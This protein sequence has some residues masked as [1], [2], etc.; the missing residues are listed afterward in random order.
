MNRQNLLKSFLRFLSVFIFI[1]LFVLLFFYLGNLDLVNAIGFQKDSFSSHEQATFDFK[2]I[3]SSISVSNI[4][5]HVYN[6]SSFG[7]RVTGSEG[8]DKA[9]NYIYN[10]LKSLPNVDVIVQEYNVTTPVSSGASITLVSKG[11]KVIKA[12]PLWP[13]LIQ[14][15]PTPPEGL[16]GR[17]VYVGRGDYK[18][19]N[20]K[21]SPGD[22]VLMDFNTKNNWQNAAELGA[23][24]VI[25][26]EPSTTNYFEEL[27]KFSQT[28]V[29]F[30]RLF[31]SASDGELLKE[32]SQAPEGLIVNVKSSI[33]YK[34]VEAKNIIGIVKGTP[35]NPTHLSGVDEEIIAVGAHYD[36]WSVVPDIA[37]GA[38]E[39]TGVAT[40]LELA[41]FFS[42]HTPKRTMWFVALSGHWEALA[43]AREFTERY[44]FSPE[45]KNG[46]KVMWMFINL[47]F[48]TDS[49][50]V[51]L[52]FVGDMY[53]LGPGPEMYWILPRYDTWINPR[54]SQYL[55]QM[56]QQLG[57]PFTK[58][59]LNSLRSDW[60]WATIPTP[61]ILDSEP[62]TVAGGAGFSLR[63]TDTYRFSWGLS[64]TFEKVNRENLELQAQLATCLVY[65]FA[66]DPNI[67]SASQLKSTLAPERLY[68][69]G[70]VATGAGFNTL[71]GNVW[72][73]NIS[74]GWYDG[75]PNSLVVVKTAQFGQP[76]YPFAKIV[77]YTDSNGTFKI[78]GLG[79]GFTAGIGEQQRVLA[80]YYVEAF[81][82]DNKTGL[83][84]YAPDFGIHGS[85]SFNFYP[86]MSSY[87]A[88][89]TTIVFKCSSVEVFNFI[90]PRNLEPNTLPDPRR[91]GS[92]RTAGSGS[93]SG[94]YYSNPW[95]IEIYNTFTL[96]RLD[97]FG[98]YYNPQEKILM[99]FLPLNASSIIVYKSGM[100]S[101]IGALF[102]NVSLQNP[103]RYSGY[104]VKGRLSLINTPLQITQDLLLISSFRYSKLSEKFIRSTISEESLKRAKELFQASKEAFENKNYDKSHTLAM[105]AWIE[106]LRGYGDTMSLIYDISKATSFYFVLIYLFVVLFVPLTISSSDLFKRLVAS[107]IILGVLLATFY[108]FHPGLS[109]ISNSFMSLFGIIIGSFFI[110]VLVLFLQQASSIAR[111][112]RLKILGAHFEKESITAS[113]AA[114]WA[115]TS[116]SNLRK[117]KIRTFLTLFTVTAITF[118][119]TSFT[120]T[121]P[122]NIPLPVSISWNRETYGS[123]PYTGFYVIKTGF[124]TNQIQNLFTSDVAKFIKD[125]L[126]GAYIAQRVWLY[127]PSSLALGGVA[128]VAGTIST[129]EG[130]HDYQIS[131]VA[132]FDPEEFYVSM[133]KNGLI[134]GYWFNESDYTSCIITKQ[135]ADSLNVHVGDYIRWAGITLNVKGILNETIMNKII[136]L[137][138]QSI[139]PWNPNFITSLRLAPSAEGIPEQYSPLSW[140]EVL[141]VPSRLALDLGGYVRSVAVRCDNST[142]AQYFAEFMSLNLLTSVYVSVNNSVKYYSNY[143]FYNLQGFGIVVILTVIGGL[144]ILSTMLGVLNERMPEIKIYSALGLSP[145]GI[146]FQFFVESLVIASIGSV[147]GYIFGLIANS[148]LVANNI[149]PS[150]YIA[151]TSSLSTVISV[152]ISFLAVLISTIYPA[153]NASKLVTPSLERRWKPP[154]AP[155]GNEWNIPLPF[156]AVDPVEV[157]GIFRYLTEYFKASLNSI[158]ETFIVREVEFREADNILIMRVDLTPVE[159]H[160]SQEVILGVTKEENRYSFYLKITRT[161]GESFAWRSLNLAFIDHFRKQLLTWRGLR[162]E[163][164]SKYIY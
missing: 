118:S 157:K 18:D 48:S 106:V 140:Q 1:V 43:G 58:L 154:T 129:L 109:L 40:L 66:N 113:L 133:V 53:Q 137:D 88:S 70:S 39:S 72:V 46:T 98:Y 9:A 33:Q 71:V 29:Y 8:C 69:R 13:N 110:L 111:E 112:Y 134:D 12:Y 77:Q 108:L 123:I 37:P 68:I 35:G 145:S 73:Y 23:K 125:N 156:S 127:P 132:G 16:E 142:E 55:R 158:V 76:Y 63:T 47:D 146:A 42:E 30:P 144:V 67:P 90:D 45:I 151:N 141:I 100:L 103:E 101:E 164:R 163:D 25:F 161:S 82:I 91:S 52:V 56:E 64:D 149:L 97:W 15:S 32:L 36:S 147:I 79:P 6:F 78:H 81:H 155:V 21:F 89:I 150:N 148:F 7:T 57:K 121:S 60:W 49:N 59:V 34:I 160:L 85:Q 84:D 41:R 159:A 24:A 22:I 136:D 4:L 116:I 115:S 20:Q 130:Q 2:E 94:T 107:L 128:V 126:P 162:P 50:K 102:L 122:S 74:K 80:G 11:G 120:S 135:M 38:D 152:A 51:G 99:F 83:I 14:A 54:V 114:M 17:L 27:S 119:L 87:P 153:F 117:R 139:A 93:Y 138:T 5:S 28:P 131:A 124:T 86:L 75:V 62:I 105:N 44:Y 26:I 104:E 96:A 19:F 61:Y 65:G 143:T 95:S 10:Y 31:V 92:I 3:V